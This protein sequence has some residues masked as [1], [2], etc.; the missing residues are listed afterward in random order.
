MAGGKLS[1]RQKMINMMYLVLLA[2]LALNVSKEVL[3]AFDIIRGKLN[4]SAVIA[5]DNA[6]AFMSNMKETINEEVENENKRINVGLLDTLDIIKNRTGEIITKINDHIGEMENIAGVDPET[7]ELE[8]KDEVDA[9]FRYWMGNNEG[10]NGGGG[11]GSAMELRQQINDYY[12]FLHEIERYNTRDPQAKNALEPEELPEKVEGKGGE[13]KSWERYHFDGP[14]IGNIA[15]LEAFKSDIYEQQKELLDLLNSRLGVATFKVDKVIALNSPVSTIV[16]AGLQFQ[17]KL[18]VAMSS[19]T[20]QPAFNSGS[21]SIEKQDD[22]TAMLTISAN[23]GNIPKGKSEG[24]QS[25]SATIQVPRSTG[26]FETLPIEGQFTVRKPEVQLTSAA[27]QNLYQLCANDVNI[28]V[29][30]LGEFYN[31]KVSAS[32]AQVVKAPENRTLF[33]IIPSG[34]KCLISVSNVLNGQTTKI[35]DLP[36]NVI[37]PPK[38]SIEFGIN[39]KRTDGLAVVPKGSRIQVI[40]V[41]D[42]DFKANLP[43][44]A[45]YG[46]TGVDVKAQLSLGTPQSVNRIGNVNDATQPVNVPLGSRVQQAPAGTKIYLEIQDIFRINFQNQKVTDNRFTASEKIFSFTV[47]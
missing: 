40:L 23:G 10:A 31:P 1:P 36:Y 34:S 43:R 19:S 38:P 47:R 32:N 22:G 26:G 25:Y 21:G 17:T 12:N 44:D 7:G 27:I 9:N 37:K 8:K 2:L 18:A 39:G 46:L 4:K 41:P 24:T 3:D 42:E 45:R 35:D 28:D 5:N 29:P 13:M 6:D 20:L 15:I 14:V 30:A 33:R 11:N 16:P